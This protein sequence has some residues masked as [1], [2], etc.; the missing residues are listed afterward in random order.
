MNIGINKTII[1]LNATVCLL[2]T[3]HYSSYKMRGIGGAG[4]PSEMIELTNATM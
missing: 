2:I 1:H 4:T 3:S